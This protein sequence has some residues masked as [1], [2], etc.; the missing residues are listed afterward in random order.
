M[1]YWKGFGSC[2]GLIEVLSHYLPGGTVETH[3]KPV[4][5]ESTCY[6]MSWNSFWESDYMPSM[7]ITVQYIW[8]STMC[9]MVWVAKSS[10][11]KGNVGRTLWE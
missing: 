9:V 7:A 11:T 1:M 8:S 10:H 3:E 4:R 6:M 5:M 2:V